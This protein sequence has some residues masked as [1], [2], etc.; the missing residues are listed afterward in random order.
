MRILLTSYLS[1]CK[2]LQRCKV[3][4][5]VSFH[6][7]FKFYLVTRHRS[8]LFVWSHYNIFGETVTPSTGEFRDSFSN[9]N[10][11][12]GDVFPRLSHI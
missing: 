3:L 2:L 9:F 10:E 7:K 6:K 12:F 11:F 1:H 5:F 8:S 4:H